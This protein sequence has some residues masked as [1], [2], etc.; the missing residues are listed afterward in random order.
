MTTGMN[1]SAPAS[2]TF[3]IRH[4]QKTMRMQYCPQPQQ[5][6]RR[7][8]RRGDDNDSEE[9]VEAAFELH[10]QSDFYTTL[11]VPTSVGTLDLIQMRHAD[12][13]KVSSLPISAQELYREAMHVLI[14]HRIQYNGFLST[15]PTIQ[16]LMSV[17]CAPDYVLPSEDSARLSDAIR[18]NSAFYTTLT[19]SPEAYM[20]PNTIRQVQSALRCLQDIFTRNNARLQL[21]R[22]N[23]NAPE[24]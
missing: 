24:A 9:E 23:R 13:R 11:C 14:C 6:R 8:R 10:T 20:L 15:I 16:M 4:S 12:E 3:R 2:P 18:V 5:H 1:T 19:A 21:Q 22:T 7:R 17:L